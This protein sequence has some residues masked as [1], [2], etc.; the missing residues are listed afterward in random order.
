MAYSACFL[1]QSALASSAARSS[2]SSSSQRYVSL[3]KPVQIVCKA[4]QPHEDD[5]S[6]VSR[7][8]ALTLLVGAAAVGS[9]VSPAD[10]AYGEAG[11]NKQKSK[12]LY[13][14]HFIF[15]PNISSNSRLKNL[16]LLF[17]VCSKCVWEAKDEH[18]LHYIQW[19]WIQSGGTSKMEPK[20]RDR[21]SRTSP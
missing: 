13:I 3:S 4:Q 2:S 15:R 10:A 9:K 12:N 19:R 7:R 1:H 18:R 8:L 17:W 21:V 11:A 5:N 16:F 6:A 20:Q 14:D